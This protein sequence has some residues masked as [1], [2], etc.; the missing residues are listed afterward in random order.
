LS[1][2]SQIHGLCQASVF[3]I[4]QCQPRPEDTAQIRDLHGWFRPS[5][6][7]PQR[8]TWFL[9][10]ALCWL[11]RKKGFSIPS[12]LYVSWY[13]KWVLLKHIRYVPGILQR[14]KPTNCGTS[15]S[16]QEPQLKVKSLKACKSKHCVGYATRAVIESAYVVTVQGVD[17]TR[18]V[19]EGEYVVTIQ[20]KESTRIVKKLITF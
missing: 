18:I 11:L 13:R 7:E 20:S 5:Q 15:A 17:S 8:C 12:I 1:Q 6:L 19:R 14:L 2:A 16:F 3:P 10:E 4:L 9:G